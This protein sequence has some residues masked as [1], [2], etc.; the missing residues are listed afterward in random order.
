LGER[1]GLNLYAYVGNNPI[2]RIDPFGLVWYN[3]FSWNWGKIGSG[4]EF[5]GG[6]GPAIGT[7]IHLGPID[8]QAKADVIMFGGYVDLGGGIGNLQEASANLDIKIG[9]FAA[10]YI[11]KNETRAGVDYCGKQTF[12]QTPSGF[13]N[14]HWV[15]GKVEGDSS[16]PYQLGVTGDIGFG[17]AT[18]SVD[19]QKIW[20]GITQ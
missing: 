2:S 3:P 5:S 7:D 1:G 17:Q 12:S 13:G 18:A 8:I 16:N 10:G 14:G 19:F 4:V 6:G 11:N 20:Q 15:F 9:P